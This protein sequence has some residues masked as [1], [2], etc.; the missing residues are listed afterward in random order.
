MNWGWYYLNTVL[1]D[2]SRYIIHWE[3]CD[4]MKADNVKRTVDIAIA[5]AKLKSKAK[6]KLLSDNAA[7]SLS[8]ELKTYLKNEL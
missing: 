4:S 1:D 5:K 2:F 3:L 7:C 8:N 6:P